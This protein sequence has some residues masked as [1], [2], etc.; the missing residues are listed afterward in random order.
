MQQSS[1]SFGKAHRHGTY[2]APLSSFHPSRASPYLQRIRSNFSFPPIGTFLP[3]VITL[4]LMPATVGGRS[5]AVLV[6]V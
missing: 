1:W 2:A 5:I 6:R 3:H 4:H